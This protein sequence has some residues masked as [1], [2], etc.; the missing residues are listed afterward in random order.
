MAMQ[1][2]VTTAPFFVMAY[3]S[4]RWPRVAGGILVALSVFFLSVYFGTTRFNQLLFLVK[5][6]TAV[7]FVGPLLA[8]G[9]AL[10]QPREEQ[11]VR[12]EGAA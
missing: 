2:L 6:A 1:L 11:R 5:I 8:S 12:V 9:V 7:L 4:R 3:V 10:L